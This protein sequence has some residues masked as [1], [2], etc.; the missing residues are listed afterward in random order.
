M[1]SEGTASQAHSAMFTQD[2][3]ASVYY[4]LGAPTRLQTT[5][6]REEPSG[7]LRTLLP[8]VKLC[9]IGLNQQTKSA[10]LCSSEDL[11]LSFGLIEF[12]LKI[13]W[14]F[15]A[16]F[17]VLNTLYIEPF[18]H[19][20]IYNICNHSCSGAGGKLIGA[21]TKDCRQCVTHRDEAN[22]TK[23]DL[24]CQPFGLWPAHSTS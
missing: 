13:L 15:T 20:V 4:R 21:K 23:K 3:N 1:K 19:L 18:A 9:P 5:P 2:P 10:A 24:N 12:I 16:L 11:Q 6:S 7:S 14:I 8:R 17:S 22:E